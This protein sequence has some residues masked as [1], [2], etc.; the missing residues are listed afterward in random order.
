MELNSI[1][2]ISYSQPSEYKFSLDSVFLSQ[3]VD[4]WLKQNQVQ[5]E[6]IADLCAGCGVV[7][8]ELL[9]HLHHRQ[10]KQPL[11]I[12]FIEVQNDYKVHFENNKKVMAQ[13][14]SEIA[15]VTASLNF[16]LENY[17]DVDRFQRK[18]DVIICNPPYFQMG[19]GKL[20]PSQFKNRCR[21]FMDSDFANLIGFIGYTLSRNGSAF[22]LLRE[23]ILDKSQLSI[24]DLSLLH[25]LEVE[26][27]G[28]IRGTQLIRLFR[29]S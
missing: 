3:R 16:M 11:L 5:A 20:S 18:Y 13:L 23:D 26:A 27:S 1:F 8:L 28:E 19:H 4:D 15:P 2:T 12:D 14:L 25:G 10:A 22:L 24:Q 9:F 6:Y 29:S 17:Q 7:G 21:F